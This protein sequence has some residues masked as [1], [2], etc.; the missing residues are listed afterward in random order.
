MQSN[1]DAATRA[2][3]VLKTASGRAAGIAAS[4][5][6]RRLVLMADPIEGED[7]VIAVFE[8]Q[9]ASD[10]AGAVFITARRIEGVISTA[11]HLAARTDAMGSQRDAGAA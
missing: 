8:S 10:L 4:L 11:V 5:R 1:H 2:Y 7:S 3:V 6:Q 9:D